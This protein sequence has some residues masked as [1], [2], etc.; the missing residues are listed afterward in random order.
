M[1]VQN[2]EQQASLLE[3]LIHEA[4]GGVWESA[5]YQASLRDIAVNSMKP[6]KV[7]EQGNGFIC[8]GRVH[9]IAGCA[10]GPCAGRLGW[11]G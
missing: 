2:T 4:G 8:P 9:L 10:A 11:M 5:F 1:L 7:S 3:I 6:L